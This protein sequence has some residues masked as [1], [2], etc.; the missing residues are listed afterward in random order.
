M[1]YYFHFLNEQAKAR[2]LAPRGALAYSRPGCCPTATAAD[3]SAL[4]HRAHSDG[5]HLGA[6]LPLPRIQRP[7]GSLPGLQSPRTCHLGQQAKGNHVMSAD[8]ATMRPACCSTEMTCSQITPE[9]AARPHEGWEAEISRL[10]LALT[11]IYSQHSF[12]I[13]Q[14]AVLLA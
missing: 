14:L 13:R 1:V 6:L 4:T 2:G 10:P 7:K 9:L 12:A 11:P 5:R 8:E 3:L